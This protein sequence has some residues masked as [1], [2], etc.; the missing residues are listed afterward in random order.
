MFEKILG[1]EIF[2]QG[3]YLS[4][5]INGSG[6]LGTKQSAPVGVHTDKANGFTRLGMVADVDG[7][8][9]GA[10]A[11]REAMLAGTAAEGF[12][13]GYDV[14]GS[15]HIH[16]NA[17]RTSK[18]QISGE[19]SLESTADGSRVGWTGSTDEDLKVEQVMT[20]AED[21]KFVR[22]D[23]TL[24]NESG[25]AMQNLRYL[26]T[27][28]PDHGPGFSTIN[29]IVEQGGDGADGALL[30]AY[31]GKGQ[32]PFFYYSSD[33]RAMVSTFGLKNYDPY[34]ALA[35]DKAQ[36]E[37]FSKSAD[38]AV[39]I[40]FAVGTLAAGESTTLTFYFG[41]TGD[42]AATVAEIKGQEGAPPQP[43]KPAPVEHAPMAVDDAASTV[44]TKAVTGNV[45]AN[46]KD[47]DGDALSATLVAGPK[48]GTVTL[49]ADGSYSYVANK[50][51]VGTD[52]FGYSASDGKAS[53]NAT[54]KISVGATPNS[55]PSA[56]DDT[57][58]TVGAKAVMGN[59]LA[60]DKDADGDALSA[61]LA[62]GPKHGTVTLAADGSYSY[63]ANKGFVGTDVFTYSASDGKASASATVK[64]SVA[65]PPNA[66]PTAAA[67]GA[68]TKGVAAAAGNVLANDKDAD[69]DALSATLVTGPKNG[70]VTLAADGSYSY[71]AN[72]GFA[73][74]DVFTYSASDGKA[75]ANAAVTIAVEASVETSDAGAALS[76]L[77]RAHV[78]HGSDAAAQVLTATAGNDVFYV[79]NSRA[80]GIDTIDGFGRGDLI[81]VKEAFHDGNRDGI[82][83]LSK[84]VVSLQH[85]ASDNALKMAGVASLRLMGADEDGTF[86]YASGAGRPK[87]ARESRMSDDRLAGDATD[88]KTQVF[89]FDSALGLDLGQDTVAN[90]G[91]KDVLVTT[92]ALTL[93]GGRVTR[94]DDGDIALLSADG[95]HELGGIDLR[96]I[97][98]GTPALEFDGT[99]IRDGATYYVYSLE[100]SSAGLGNVII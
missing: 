88:K 68:A 72:K 76:L 79:D 86:V 10:G 4:L 91:R 82:I 14:G 70:T 59:V 47:A 62:S 52:S 38:E 60:N 97:G 65:A 26:R 9:A 8:G 34:T 13:I 73:G 61:T 84:G 83:N 94:D 16:I 66:A 22:V 51:F 32:T 96:G 20:V 25:A 35:M 87:G 40:N 19:T 6:T 89:F 77:K 78:Q 44:A 64:V 48:N 75:S 30:A 81:G 33:E 53:A 39:N 23:V 55:G 1:D 11:T 42:L 92:T 5:G 67:D 98:G 21:A 71:V 100:G 29:T 28:D 57:A 95:A 24:T 36:A 17:E 99:I 2:L 85:P 3:K 80:S 27:I 46:D 41:I 63:V 93:D 56:I 58:S 31:A 43:T 74:T 54:V 18:A 12:T 50:G 49:A 69:G 37:G 7:F 90:F 15:R 45:L